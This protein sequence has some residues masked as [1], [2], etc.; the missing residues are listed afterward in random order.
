MP[1]KEAIKK[2]EE[3]RKDP[4]AKVESEKQPREK[5]PRDNKEE[6]LQKRKKEKDA[7]KHLEVPPKDAIKNL[8]VEVESEKQPKEKSPKDDGIKNP[9][10]PLT[11]AITNLEEPQRDPVEAVVES[12]KQPKEESSLKDQKFEKLPNKD[13]IKELKSNPKILKRRQQMRSKILIDRERTQQPIGEDPIK[14]RE[15]P[16]TDWYKKLEELEAVLAASRALSPA[17]LRQS[18]LDTYF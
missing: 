17:A 7:I 11:D 3:P 16:Q 8:V 10:V 18:L 6:K 4:E 12:E 15:E 2:L 9:E 5:S 13:A 1:P 14:H